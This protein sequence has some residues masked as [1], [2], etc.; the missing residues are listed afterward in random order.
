M[1]G[2]SYGQILGIILAF[3]KKKR[4]KS[5]KIPNTIRNPTWIWK[6]KFMWNNDNH[7]PNHEVTYL[8]NHYHDNLS[9]EM[10]SQYPGQGSHQ[11]SHECTSKVILLAQTILVSLHWTFDISLPFGSGIQNSIWDYLPVFQN[12]SHQSPPY[13]K[14]LFVMSTICFP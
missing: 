3:V 10:D 7:L 14:I 2:S 11:E 5:H 4:K 12:I 9:S 6:Q 8:Q 13:S 1:E